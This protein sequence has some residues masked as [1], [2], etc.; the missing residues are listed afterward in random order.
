ME[1]LPGWRERD[2]RAIPLE[3]HGLKRVL[4]LV[5]VEGHRPLAD[6]ELLGRPGHASEI[7]RVVE[8]VELP[9]VRGP[10]QDEDGKLGSKSSMNRSTDADGRPSRR[11]STPYRRSVK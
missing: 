11:M 4:D 10:Y 1:P 3:Q 2:A 5:Y 7:C 8:C 9:A 6:E